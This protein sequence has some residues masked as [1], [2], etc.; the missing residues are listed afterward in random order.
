MNTSRKTTDAAHPH[1]PHLDRWQPGREL[2][3]AFGK[4]D[5]RV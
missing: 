5:G 1:P 3:A 4:T 2:R